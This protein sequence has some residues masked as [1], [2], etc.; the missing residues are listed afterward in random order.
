LISE[1]LEW[2]AL[3]ADAIGIVVLMLGFLFAVV[4]FV[5]TLWQSSGADTIMQIQEIRCSLGT[6][7]VF[8]LEL[9]IISDL[10]HSVTSR[11]LEDLYFL[12]AIV[13][14]RTAIG[15]FLGL[16]IQELAAAHR[17]QKAA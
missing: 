5:P 14:I 12:G 2:A 7:I 16:E 11:E 9:M 4:R 3:G 15:Y 10:L 6:Y 17:E 8:A 1:F 13:V